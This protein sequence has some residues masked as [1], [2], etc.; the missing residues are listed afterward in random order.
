M[1]IRIDLNLHLITE[2][3]EE[4]EEEDRGG[5]GFRIWCCTAAGC[6][7]FGRLELV[8]QAAAATATRENSG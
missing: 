6:Y 8:L 2:K 1:Q 3:K 4:E 7:K 5:G